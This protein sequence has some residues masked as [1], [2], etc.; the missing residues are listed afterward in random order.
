MALLDVVK[1]SSMSQ[2]ATTT[3]RSASAVTV[4]VQ[5]D[6]HCLESRMV[7]RIGDHVRFQA[8]PHLQKRD[9]PIVTSQTPKTVW[10]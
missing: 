8:V 10:W 6:E 2:T 7:F 1:E 9:F 5:S 3:S 4:D